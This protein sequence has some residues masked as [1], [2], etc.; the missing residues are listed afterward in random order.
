MGDLKA[1]LVQYDQ[2][3]SVNTYIIHVG[4]G[5]CDQNIPFALFRENLLGTHLGQGL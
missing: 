3:S 2:E 1:M 4:Q 5:R